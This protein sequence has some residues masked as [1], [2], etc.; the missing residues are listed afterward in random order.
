MKKKYGIV[1]LIIIMS[2]CLSYI[3]YIQSVSNA[4]ETGTY[5]YLYNFFELGNMK[6]TIKDYL[7]PWF[8]CSAIAYLFNIGG[9]GSTISFAYLVVWYGIAVFFTLLLAMYNTQNKWLLALAFFILLPY[10]LTNKY[11]LVATIVTLFCL[12]CIQC[13]QDYKKKW[14]LAIIAL[15]ILYTLLFTHDRV[16]L[17]LFVFATVVVYYGII[18]LQD[19]D[20]RKYLYLL[21]FFA[22][23][24]A[25]VLKGVDVI[26]TEILGKEAGITEAW[27]GYGG[28]EYLTWIDVHTLFDKGIPSFL[29]C[30]FVQWNIPMEGGM[31]QFNSFYWIIR[32]IIAILA[33]IAVVIR[34]VDIV[35]KGI[36]NV[37]LL[38]SL[39]VICATVV[40]CINMLNGMV[41][42]YDIKHSPMNRYASICWFLLVVILIRWINEHYC[43]KELYYKLSTNILLGVIFA[44]LSIG[45]VGPIYKGNADTI[46]KYCENELAYLKEYG[47]KYQYGLASFWKA[48]PITAATNGEHVVCIGGVDG[49]KLTCKTPYGFYADGSNYFNFLISDPEN[50][51]TMSPENIEKVRGDYVDIYSNTGVFY[52]YDYDIRFEPRLIMEAVETDYELVEPIEYHFDFPVGTNR[53]EMTVANSKNFELDIVDNPDVSNVVINKLDD[54][55]I[56]VDIVCLQNTNV[57]FKVARKADEFTTI[58]KIMLKRVKAAITVWEEGQDNVSEVYLKEGSYIFTFLGENIDELKVDWIGTNIETEQLTDGKMRRRYCVNVPISQNM[59]YFV[60]GEKVSIDKI[61][62]ENAVLFDEK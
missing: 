18:V 39:C 10:E 9:S 16:I 4:D 52:L 45:Y 6:L 14:I 58:H 25:M 47:D 43:N 42:Y 33:I 21:V 37:A 32:L 61:S 57:T 62:Y 36:K 35:K 38:D 30:L 41:W 29:S 2:I 34:W 27:T 55:K 17:L 7:N 49:E 22:A 46:N 13:Y 60:A 26:S 20:K 1:S 50:A 28:D 44:M 15:V 48:N 40:A 5:V 3:L 54:N 51:M 53:I 59:Q 31:I 8:Y 56:Q 11:H 23:F 24:G 12:W 19:K